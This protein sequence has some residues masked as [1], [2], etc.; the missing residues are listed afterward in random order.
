M[1]SGVA[2]FHL[3]EEAHDDCPVRG[4]ELVVAEEVHQRHAL[5]VLPGLG[6]GV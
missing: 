5:A 4:K 3:F 6:F 2:F 1:E